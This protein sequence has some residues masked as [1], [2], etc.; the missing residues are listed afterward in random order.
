[1][2]ARFSKEDTSS[3]TSKL[4]LSYRESRMLGR[5]FLERE[6]DRMLFRWLKVFIAA[7]LLCIMVPGHFLAARG[8][9]PAL[10]WQTLESPRFAVHFFEGQRNLPPG[11]ANF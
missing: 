5:T 6:E 8:Y 3:S 4:A 9:D 10:E 2:R 7:S 1:M 11:L